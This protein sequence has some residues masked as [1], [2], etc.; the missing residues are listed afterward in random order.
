M[1]VHL[2]VNH[3]HYNIIQGLV[4]GCAALLARKVLGCSRL[5]Y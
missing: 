1:A 5:M 3:M 2:A 4:S